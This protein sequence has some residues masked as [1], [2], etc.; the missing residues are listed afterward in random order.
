MSKKKPTL[1]IP[2]GIAFIALAFATI[3]KYFLKLGNYENKDIFYIVAF[4]ALSG[5]ACL[6]MPKYIKK[7][8]LFRLWFF[9]FTEFFIRATVYGRVDFFEYTIFEADEARRAYY[10]ETQVNL[11]P[12]ESIKCVLGLPFSGIFTNIFGNIGLIIPVSFLLPF[13]FPKEKSKFILPLLSG[14]FLSLTAEFLQLYFMCGA[15]DVDDLILNSLGALIGAAAIYLL[16]AK[17]K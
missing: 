1:N 16:K 4:I 13:A 8:A 2:I 9:L 11:I 5:I 14:V 17:A 3:L 7:E 15:F 6:L 12:F 10:F